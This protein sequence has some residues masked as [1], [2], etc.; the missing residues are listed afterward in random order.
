MSTVAAARPAEM[1]AMEKPPQYHTLVNA[2]LSHKQSLFLEYPA[3]G[4]LNDLCVG[5][6]KAPITHGSHALERD[7]LCTHLGLAT[8]PSFPS[9]GNGL[10]LSKTVW[11][12]QR[13][14]IHSYSRAVPVSLISP[15]STFLENRH[16]GPMGQRI[17]EGFA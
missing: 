10:F 4:T 13:S 6:S 5:D 17:V 9:E 3:H 15:Y 16:L 11:A 2:H 14:A 12:F 7:L 8:L 1:R